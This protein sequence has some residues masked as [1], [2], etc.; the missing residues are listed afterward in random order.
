VGQPSG[1]TVVKTPAPAFARARQG[2]LVEV[3][4]GR[5]ADLA[6]V[7]SLNASVF[8][9][10]HSA[11]PGAVICADYRLASP[12]S[13]HVAHAWSRAMRVANRAIGRSALLLDPSNTIFNLQVERI[14]RCAGNPARRLFADVA[15]LQD[16][17][18]GDLTEPER[19]ALLAFL[20]HVAVDEQHHGVSSEWGP[21]LRS[22]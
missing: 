14:V 5:L 22:G 1:E 21:S 20:N 7:D 16:W 3:R 17:V 11:G 10:V 6:E 15:E 18:D 8:A 13:P 19:E 9:A 12:V 4:V 2:R